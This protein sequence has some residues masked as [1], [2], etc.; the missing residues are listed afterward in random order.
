[1]DSV[2]DTVREL[3]ARQGV[4]PADLDYGRWELRRAELVQM[5]ALSR[6]C[7]F[8]VDVYKGVYDYISEG[9]ADL[10]GMCP[11]TIEE[12]LHPADREKIADLQ[13]RHAKFIYSLPPSERNDY[14][15]IY[16]VRMRGAG[17]NIGAGFGTGTGTGAGADNRWLN[18][19]SRNQVIETDATGTAWIV[20]G[21]IELAPDQT[22]TDR[23]RC[24]VLNLRTGQFFNPY[25]FSPEWALTDRELE[26]LSLMAQ[27][28]LSKE[29]AERLSV[30]KHTIDNHRKNI[31]SKL[32]S[33][34]A[35]EAINTARAAGLI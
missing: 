33:D 22:P 12:L 7:V 11:E 4:S 30:S 8:A 35:I 21:M 15:T 16:Q 9:F 3:W 27:G 6:G 32:E 31:L 17:S 10:F 29:I 2:Q 1:M 13:I 14:R 28:L 20:M 5:A 19:T 18:V 23:V 26:I 25:A 24:S 34:N